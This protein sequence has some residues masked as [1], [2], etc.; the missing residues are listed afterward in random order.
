MVYCLLYYLLFI[1]YCQLST[2]LYYTQLTKYSIQ[3]SATNHSLEHDLGKNQSKVDYS[4]GGARIIRIYRGWS[5]ANYQRARSIQ[6]IRV[7]INKV[8]KKVENVLGLKANYFYI[9]A[10]YQNYRGFKKKIL[11]LLTK[12][13]GTTSY[14]VTTNLLAIKI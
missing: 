3:H 4:L 11:L 13:L 12:T 14:S 10:L 8:K 1:V 5:C 2:G 6:V 7:V 9:R